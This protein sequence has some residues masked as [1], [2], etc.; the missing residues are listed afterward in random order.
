MPPQP[1]PLQLY[2]YQH[3]CINQAKSM[4]TIVNL[5]TGRGKTLIAA[6]LIDH[7]LEKAPTKKV[8]FL[9]PT[10]PLVEQ[11]AAYCRDKCRIVAGTSRPVIVQ[12]IVGQDQASWTQSDWDEC[13]D[14]SHVILGTA[15]LFQQAF[16]TD[17]YLDITRFS[18]IVFDEC[19]NA[20]GN[21]PMAAVMRDCVAPLI[22]NS[23]GAA[24]CT[25]R[26]LGLTASFVNGSLRDIE[27]KRKDL[28]A[29]LQSTIICPNVESKL[30][31]NDKFRRVHWQQNANIDKHKEAI[32]THVENAIDAVGPVK[33]ITKVIN[34]CIHVFEELGLSAL[35]FYVETVIV[36]QVLEKAATLRGQVDDVAAVRFAN[37]LL[38]GLPSLHGS[39]DALKARLKADFTVQQ[40]A[41]I[42]LKL[43]RLIEILRTD[44]A[45]KGNGYRGIVFVEQV[46]LVSPLAKQLNDALHASSI[47]AAAVAGGG[48][49][50][51][52]ERQ[53]LL[54]KFKNGH[55]QILV[56]TATLE[57]GI[58]VSQCEFVVR[59]THVQTTKAHIQG[60]GR[61]RHP[62]AIVYY[63]ENNPD[64]ERQKE[65]HMEATARNISLSLNA[66]EF[67]AAA[68]SMSTSVDQVHPYPF[69]STIQR[70]ASAQDGSNNSN[71]T[72]EV[73]VFN[74]KQ[75]FNQYCS[76]TLGAS[77]KPSQ[78]LYQYSSAAGEK[79]RLAKIRAPTPNG[80]FTMSE[81]DYRA[82]WK[83][84]DLDKVF[85]AERM[86]KKS[87]SDLEEMAFVY[88]MTVELRENGLLDCHNQPNK[89]IL[90]DTKRRCSLA[91][92]WS[93][94]IR[95]KTTVSQSMRG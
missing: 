43:D 10:R 83:N 2:S 3:D 79:K 1:P 39:L 65:G 16:V 9:V 66:L 28:E 71:R 23:G 32:S 13:M 38:A 89:S 75:I 60:A 50:N 80:W 12:Q 24:Q 63:F 48:Y 7:F 14:K 86:K 58:D 61:A 82:F 11:Q 59:F 33:E 26:I 51:E 37:R 77:I 94:A 44:F 62:D 78:D 72:G 93:E 15:A 85:P 8:A 64:V 57:E 90:F 92:D 21:S 74:C 22:K 40:A 56:A 27:K 81:Y 55:V 25:P 31:G 41:P 54:D 95:F 45:A 18:L 53:G 6:R 70:A 76:I 42:S 46:A 68:V 30:A 52:T 34:R 5:P 20:V 35:E 17:K 91:S 87:A 36:Q 73:N 67:H 29:L 4:N 84:V 49:Q 69:S 47:K 88:M 19:H